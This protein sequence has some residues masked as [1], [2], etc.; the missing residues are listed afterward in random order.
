MRELA[1]LPAGIESDVAGKAGHHH[2]D[3]RQ[4]NSKTTAMSDRYRERGRKGELLL[5]H[6]FITN[7]DS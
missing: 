3:Q 1:V 6:R 7:I 5:I 2:C 4:E